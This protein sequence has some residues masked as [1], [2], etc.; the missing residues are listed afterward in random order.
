[1]ASGISSIFLPFDLEEL[2]KRLELLIQEKQARKNSILIDEEIVAILDKLLENNC[3][4]K[5]QN[6][7]ILINCNLFYEQVIFFVYTNL[8]TSIIVC[9]HKNNCK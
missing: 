9:K 5:K 6:W 1:M 4:S 8:I 3:I 2:C 7:K